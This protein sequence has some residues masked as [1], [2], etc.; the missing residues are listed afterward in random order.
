MMQE[1]QRASGAAAL[2]G[3]GIRIIVCIFMMLLFIAII[4]L[5]VIFILKALREPKHMQPR[6]DYGAHPH[7]SDEAIAILNERYAKGEITQ[8]E[9]LRTKEDILKP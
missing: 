7:S 4:T 1:F 3:S 2:F 9:Y 5:A 6:M 8:E